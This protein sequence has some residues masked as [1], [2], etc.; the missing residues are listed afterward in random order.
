MSVERPLLT[1]EELHQWIGKD[2]I[3][4]RSLYEAVRRGDFE[5]VRIGKRLY[6]LHA[7][8]LRSWGLDPE[9]SET[10]PTGTPD[11]QSLPDRVLTDR[12]CTS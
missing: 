1:V 2:R 11:P 9:I 10:S 6:V 4:E 3:S 5:H 7:P 12:A 8:P